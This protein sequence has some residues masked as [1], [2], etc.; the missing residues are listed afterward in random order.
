MHPALRLRN[1]STLPVFVRRFATGATTGCEA[2]MDK[3]V[4]RII[5]QRDASWGFLPVLY[6]NLDPL[7]IPDMDMLDTDAPPPNLISALSIASKSIEALAFMRHIP[8]EVCR[9]LWPRVWSWIQVVEVHSS[10]L[11]HPRPIESHRSH[12]S[13][14]V[15]SMLHDHS[16]VLMIHNTPGVHT[17]FA[18]T[19]VGLT[20]YESDHLGLDM[21][22]NSVFQF[23]Y[24]SQWTSS[25]VNEFIE[26]CGGI[27]KLAAF[28]VVHIKSATNSA[29]S[30]PFPRTQPGLLAL[31]GLLRF[32]SRVSHARL[33][34]ML[35]SMKIVPALTEALIM[36]CETTEDGA[37]DGA[38]G[39]LDVCLHFFTTVFLMLGHPCLPEALDAGL[40]HGLLTVE[41]FRSKKVD[42]CFYLDRFMG[43][44]LPG[45]M[46]YLPVV[47]ATRGKC[48]SPYSLRTSKYWREWTVLRKLEG[49]RTQLLDE[50]TSPEYVATQ[51]CDGP[52]C[53]SIKPLA[54]IKRCSGCL[55]HYYCSSECQSAAWREGNHRAFCMNLQSLLERQAASPGIPRFGRREE[56]FLR[57]LVLRDY[58][59]N[60][61]DILLKQL[62]FVH[63]TK[64]TEFATVFSY[65]EGSCAISVVPPEEASCASGLT[66]REFRAGMVYKVILAGGQED[67]PCQ[68]G[69][70]A[71]DCLLAHIFHLRADSS[72]LMDGVVRIAG[73]LPE[74]AE[75]ELL[76]DVQPDLFEEVRMLSEL[77]I[78]ETFGSRIRRT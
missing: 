14:C 20:P 72:V 75:V 40:L 57:F 10:L 1:L 59:G 65:L 39:A 48:P 5:L 4:E 32:V 56:A 8:P 16:S 67:C 55:S 78:K 49:E 58:L 50:L 33:F 25:N 63:R 24:T 77:K 21:A 60:K 70:R 9:E 17:F 62:A 66:D 38:E 64:S 69:S 28:T 13:G 26:G 6:A 35:C 43:D 23:M 45:A 27:T 44:I 34:G 68:A 52:Q 47:S 41:Q 42:M 61:L 36:L 3:V 22:I 54:E 18:R 73:M 76:G 19:W 29:D 2:D 71:H 30:H 46:V 37:E 15:L 11:P 7:L 31:Q 51:A 74:G 53:C 12:L